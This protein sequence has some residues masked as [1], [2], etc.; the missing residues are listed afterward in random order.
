MKSNETFTFLVTSLLIWVVAILIGNYTEG[1]YIREYMQNNHATNSSVSAVEKNAN[2]EGAEALMGVVQRYREILKEDPNNKEALLS[3]AELAFQGGLL[4]KAQNYYERYLV[5][6]P[7]DI[8]AKT[9]Y[10]LTLVQIGEVKKAVSLLNEITKNNPT[11]FQP[12]LT[13][14]VAEQAQGNIS[15]AEIAAKKALKL[16]PDA[17]GKQ[18]IE[19]FLSSLSKERD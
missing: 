19:K 9:N 5:V 4:D 8:R 1:G 11:V 7:D 12:F 16:A 6:A 15:N 3:I 17:E 13:L 2:H 14:A 18:L 10:S